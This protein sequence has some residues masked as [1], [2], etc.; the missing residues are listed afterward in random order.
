MIMPKSSTMISYKNI[1]AQTILLNARVNIC[2]PPQTPHKVSLFLCDFKSFRE[3]K[4]DT[5]KKNV[6]VLEY[7]G[8]K[9][10]NQSRQKTIYRGSK[11]EKQK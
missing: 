2:Y 11:E 1:L 6:E 10:E 5:E 7:R 9:A 4:K 8:T 3:K